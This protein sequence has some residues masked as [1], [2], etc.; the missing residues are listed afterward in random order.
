MRPDAPKVAPVVLALR[1]L[2][3]HH[4]TGAAIL[5]ITSKGS[6]VEDCKKVFQYYAAAV[7]RRRSIRASVSQIH[8]VDTSRRRS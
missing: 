4:A 5:L 7:S 6:T 3:I 1:N 8:A 2:H